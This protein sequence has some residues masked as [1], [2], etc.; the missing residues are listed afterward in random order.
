MISLGDLE[1]TKCPHAFAAHGCASGMEEWNF[2]LDT[3]KRMAE[4]DEDVASYAASCLKR[5][6][7]KL[8]WRK[9]KTVRRRERRLAWGVTK[10]SLPTIQEEKA[11]DFFLERIDGAELDDFERCGLDGRTI[12][13]R[14]LRSLSGMRS[15]SFELATVDVQGDTQ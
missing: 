12:F 14:S 5:S 13:T 15:T 3:T 7:A 9:T 1:P 10:S 4:V 8:S 6:R 2:Y 11:C